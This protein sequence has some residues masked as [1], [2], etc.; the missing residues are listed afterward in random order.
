MQP[1]YTGLAKIDFL[2]KLGENIEL[3][4]PAGCIVIG[5][6]AGFF[7]PNLVHFANGGLPLRSLGKD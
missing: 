7:N 1:T 4:Q 6:F 3:I 5:L 2:K